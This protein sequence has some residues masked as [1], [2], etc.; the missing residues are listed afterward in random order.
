M[1][2][3]K[4]SP[5]GVSSVKLYQDCEH[6]PLDV[7]LDCLFDK[8]YHRLIISG[9][10]GEESLLNI[11]QNLYMQY[12]QMAGSDE[13][14]YHLQ[15]TLE[16]N[17]AL[18]T[19][20]LVDGVVSALSVCYSTDLVNLLEA[21]QLKPGISLEDAEE[22]RLEKLQ[23]VITRAKRYVVVYD[24][25]K[26]ELEA[27]EARNEKNRGSRAHYDDMLSAL[28]RH[29]G[30][31]VKPA[32]ITVARFVRESKRLREYLDRAQKNQRS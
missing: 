27:L 30:Y 16:V 20:A 31:H 19:I 17:T 9:E 3:L 29:N 21:L 8:Q 11:W 1:G 24:S 10:Q 26:K 7:F 13:L 22:L 32:D 25:K 14:D 15:L 4:L 28:S 2:P 6:C 18:S 23:K 5:K 12:C